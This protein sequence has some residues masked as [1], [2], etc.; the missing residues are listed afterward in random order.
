ML[1][2]CFRAVVVIAGMVVVGAIATVKMMK[3]ASTK[4]LVKLM[5]LVR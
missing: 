4:L 1:I 3:V 2:L 5:N